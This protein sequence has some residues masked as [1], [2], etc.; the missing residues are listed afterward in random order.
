MS[1]LYPRVISISR[2]NIDP[3][4]GDQGYGAIRG[5]VDETIV[6]SGL[7]A[8]LQRDRQ[9]QRNPVGLPTD[10]AYKPIWHVYIPG[11]QATR[12][13]VIANDVVTDDLGIRYQCFMP[14]WDSLG[15]H[16]SCIVLEP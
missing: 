12:D 4:I 11:S 5:P 8:S 7:N 9:G 3:G 16:L 14:Y 1:F 13:S 2:P 10:A 6:L 15:C